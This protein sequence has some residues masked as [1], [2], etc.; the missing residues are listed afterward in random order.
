MSRGVWSRAS[1]TK[2][3]TR[4]VCQ[5]FSIPA[6]RVEALT[7]LVANVLRKTESDLASGAIVSVDDAGVRVDRLPV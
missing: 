7:T 3:S 2:D 6:L 5:S 4:A 1:A